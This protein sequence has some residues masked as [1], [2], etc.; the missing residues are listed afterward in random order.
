MDEIFSEKESLLRAVYPATRRP[1]FWNNGRLSSAALKDKRGLSVE[2]T[3]DR[4]IKDAVLSMSRRF[5]GLIV[6]ITVPAC[7]A[8]KA[9]IKYCPSKNS[10]YHS[11]IHGSQTQV[12]LSDI[13][14]LLLARSATIQFVPNS[15]HSV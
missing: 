7:N 8:V 3:Y 1:D 4:A 11:E 2:R 5:Q 10:P 12:V 14:A 13:Q 6:S 9:Y 15:E